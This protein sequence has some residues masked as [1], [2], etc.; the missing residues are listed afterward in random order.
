MNGYPEVLMYLVFRAAGF[1][2]LIIFFALIITIAFW[3]TY[4][5]CLERTGILTSQ[6]WLRF[7]V[8]PQRFRRGE[9][10]RRCFQYS[11]PVS[12]WSFSISIAG[13]KKLVWS[14]G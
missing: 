8:R 4:R 7:F 11:L 12:F 5:L 2:G 9:F 3:T 13:I 6:A 1:A 10:G 14:G